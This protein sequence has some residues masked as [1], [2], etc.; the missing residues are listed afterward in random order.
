MSVLFQDESV[1][2]EMGRDTCLFEIIHNFVL[3]VLIPQ[4]FISGKITVESED[5]VAGLMH[6]GIAIL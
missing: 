5:V 6:F 2:K 1:S 4:V 3:S